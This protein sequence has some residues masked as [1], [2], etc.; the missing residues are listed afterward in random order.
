MEKDFEIIEVQTRKGILSKK[1]VVKYA[2]KNKK[3]GGISKQLFDKV[4]A[5][6]ESWAIVTKGNKKTI[7]NLKT[8]N[9]TDFFKEIYVV[10]D[11]AYVKIGKT[12]TFYNIENGSYFKVGVQEPNKRHPNI[13]AKF[14]FRSLTPEAWGENCIDDFYFTLGELLSD[15]PMDFENLPSKMF[16]EEKERVKYLI[17]KIAKELNRKGYS[18]DAYA[19]KNEVYDL[20]S[21]KIE[22]EK[23]PF[24]E[25][26]TTPA[27]K[28]EVAD[29]SPKKQATPI[30][31]TTDDI[32]DLGK[33]L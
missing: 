32:R 33:S 6:A 22:K 30:R 19:Y 15:S 31:R 12:W 8:G 24:P 28:E 18:D 1:T 11:L 25:F 29:Y 26:H 3:T 4:E 17:D 9:F 21:R 10:D 5:E 13:L 14:G 23:E 7:V 2:F 16:K 27:K 20:I